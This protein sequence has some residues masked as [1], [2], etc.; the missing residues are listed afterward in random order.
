MVQPSRDL[1]RGSLELVILTE[2]SDDSRYGYQILSGLKTRSGGRVDLKAGT[3]Y[4][5]LHKLERDGFV[6]SHW[7]QTSGRD[8]K[9]YTLTERGRAKLRSDARA[10]LDYS[11]CVRGL[12][13]PILNLLSPERG[14]APEP[15][16]N[17]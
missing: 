13:H 7:D 14:P 5:L 16:P 6:S 1:L 3:L 8:R 9:F 17:R 12:L 10:W 4:P 2:L 15:E 11:A